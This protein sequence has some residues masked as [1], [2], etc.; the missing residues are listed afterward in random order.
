[1]DNRDNDIMRWFIWCCNFYCFVWTWRGPNAN[2]TLEIQQGLGISE[3]VACEIL[4]AGVGSDPPN[5][6]CHVFEGNHGNIS[7]KK[8]KSWKG[9]YCNKYLF[10]KLFFFEGAAGV[11]ILHGCFG[12]CGKTLTRTPVPEST[13]SPAGGERQW[14]DTSTP[15]LPHQRVVTYGAM[16]KLNNIHPGLPKPPNERNSF[17][18]CWFWVW[19]M[20]QGYVGKFL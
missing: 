7:G 2:I 12:C 5:I 6:A 9:S 10:G 3:R 4:K 18:N 11:K 19:G 15:G 20:F 8:Q 17:I 13:S 14:K 1:M 16:G